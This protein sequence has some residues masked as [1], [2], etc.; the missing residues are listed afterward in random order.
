MTQEQLA[1]LA[2]LH[3]RT[4]RGLES[5]R[6]H[7]PRRISIALLAR[8]LGLDATGQ[9]HLLEAW[10]H[11]ATGPNASP[12]PPQETNP[13]TEVERALLRSWNSVRSIHISEHVVIGSHRAQSKWHTEEVTEALVDGVTGRLTFYSPEEPSIDLDRFRLANTINCQVVREMISG[14]GGGKTFELSFGITLDKGATHVSRYTVD[15]DAARTRPPPPTAEGRVISGFSRPPSMYLVEVQFDN[16]E[17]PAY[18]AQVFQARPDGIVRTLRRL[19][20]SPTNS[21]HVTL[22]DPKP[23]G[24]GIMWRW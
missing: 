10:G 21:V 13:A 15:W 6:I 18:C 11:V 2:G 19:H 4:V 23:G 20:V 8:A 12:G 24:H 9:T 7:A 14:E 22:I 5:G 3:V 17:V 1:E 16:V